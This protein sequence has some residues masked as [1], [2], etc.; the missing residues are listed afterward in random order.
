MFLIVMVAQEDF[1]TEVLPGGEVGEFV[2]Q[3]PLMIGR[4]RIITIFLIMEL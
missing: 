4:E 1:Q 3:M 2:I